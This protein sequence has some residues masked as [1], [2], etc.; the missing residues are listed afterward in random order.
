EA[1]AV[2]ALAVRLEQLVRPDAAAGAFARRAGAVPGPDRLLVHGRDQVH[3]RFGHETARVVVNQQEERQPLPQGR[4]AGAGL[5]EEGGPLGGRL[6]Q[7]QLEERL[8][9]HAR[10][11]GRFNAGAFPAWG[12]ASGPSGRAAGRAVRAGRPCRRRS[13]GRGSRQGPL[14]ATGGPW[15]SWVSPWEGRAP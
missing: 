1:V 12:L 13:R 2:P 10:A 8:F 6:L 11:P 14:R 3:R 5:L 7:G 9:V 15:A 4:V